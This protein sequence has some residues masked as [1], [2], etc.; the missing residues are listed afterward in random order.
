MLSRADA[1]PE[2][3]FR[4]SSVADNVFRVSRSAAPLL[5]APIAREAVEV[6]V[7]Y[8]DYVRRQE[9]AVAR[10]QKHQA[11]SRP[12]MRP[13]ARLRAL[14][15]CARSP[16]CAPSRL[17]ATAAGRPRW[18]G[19]RLPD[20]L[21]YSRLACLSNEEARVALQPRP[22]RTEAHLPSGPSPAS[23]APCPHALQP[24][25][26]APRG[27]APSALLARLRARL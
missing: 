20:D 18:Q 21:D 26:G 4:F 2:T 15:E 14:A 9:E 27:L 3:D 5:V 17:H 10:L 23:S 7:K 1:V 13:R 24:H 25:L 12:P 19:L 6:A 16:A 11:A 8:G 22:P